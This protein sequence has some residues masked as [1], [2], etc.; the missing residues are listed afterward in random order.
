MPVFIDFE[1]SG[2]DHRS[3]PI[4]V[5]W[6]DAGG[7]E[8]W[9]IRPA[10]GWTFWSA[11]A[12]AAHGISQARLE[13]VGREP[14]EVAERMNAGLSGQTV[15]ADGLPWDAHWL[16]RLFEAA[17]LAPAFELRD[18]WTLFRRALPVRPSIEGALFGTGIDDPEA[19]L[20]AF[21]IQARALAGPAH[22][23]ANDVRYLI[24]LWELVQAD[25]RAQQEA[26]DAHAYGV[27]MGR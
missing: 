13:A 22:R 12:E 17:G 3:Y 15:Y 14:W 6:G 4:Q 27:L 23:A 11:A 7:L 24:A 21:S 20:Q 10:A 9:E 5:A 18:A 1:A 8:V 26:L 25:A 2:L 16:V 19:R